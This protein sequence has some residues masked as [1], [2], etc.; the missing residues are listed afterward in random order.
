MAIS[1]NGIA[2]SWRCHHWF[3]FHIIGMFVNMLSRQSII[4]NQSYHSGR[5]K[6]ILAC[7]HAPPRPFLSEG[8]LGRPGWRL[9]GGC[10]KK[11]TASGSS[12]SATSPSAC[13]L[14]ATGGGSA[15]GVTSEGGAGATSTSGPQAYIEFPVRSAWDE[16]QRESFK[17]L[18]DSTSSMMTVPNIFSG[19]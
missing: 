9:G 12:A 11:T 16:R 15:G 14:P 7:R 18:Y 5:D 1:A 4:T 2:A 3:P 17:T 6:K 13:R 19:Y 8:N 10:P